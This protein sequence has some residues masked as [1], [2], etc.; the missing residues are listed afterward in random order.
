M[1]THNALLWNSAISGMLAGNLSDRY[2]TAVNSGT[3]PALGTPDVSYAALAT[4]ATTFATDN[5][6]AVAPDI[7][8][9]PQ[10]AGSAPISASTPSAGSAI[11]PSTGLGGVVQA[12][13]GKTRLMESI[14][15]G[16]MEGKYASQPLP[17][18]TLAQLTALSSVIAAEYLAS[19]PGLQPGI[20]SGLPAANNA[21]LWNAAFTGFL[22]GALANRVPTAT[23]STDA[24]YVAAQTMAAAFA[25]EF[26]SLVSN[27]TTISQGSGLA[28]VPTT[29]LI[30][31]TQF[32][33]TRLAHSIALGMTEGRYL[34]GVTAAMYQA[35]A[36]AAETCYTVC[37]LSINLSTAAPGPPLYQGPYNGILWNAAFCGFIAGN[38]S[39]RPISNVSV[40][41]PFYTLLSNAAVAFAGEVDKLVGGTDISGTP[42]P[43]GSAITAGISENSEVTL[44]AVPNSSPIATNEFAKEGIMWAICRGVNKGRPLLGNSLDYTQANYAPIAASV[45]ALYLE[46]TT[47]LNVV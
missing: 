9:T 14:V 41:D 47:A 44:A 10:P 45:V 26:D 32:A 21:V 1:T 18:G 4:F 31:S 20:S 27:D 19:V 33:K 12:Q 6:A 28:L 46:M 3:P 39:G 42:V 36:Q 30:A 43:T 24:G 15:L 13:Y 8:G 34:T 2:L 37:L 11:V 22:G 16:V 5:D 17:T 40:N 23:S 25:L 38:L 7:V 29:N 35:Q